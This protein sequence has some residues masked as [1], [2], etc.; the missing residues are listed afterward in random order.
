MCAR[1]DIKIEQIETGHF[2]VT[3]Q[4]HN[5]NIHFSVAQRKQQKDFCDR[6]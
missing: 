5:K 1:G 2:L 4:A 3:K 6:C